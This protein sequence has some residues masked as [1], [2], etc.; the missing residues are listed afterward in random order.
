MYKVT[1]NYALSSNTTMF[2]GMADAL[3]YYA[4]CVDNAYMYD[5]EVFSITY[6]ETD[7]IRLVYRPEECH[8]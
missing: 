8:A 4:E 1:I 2:M 6:A 5:E 7:T 3:R